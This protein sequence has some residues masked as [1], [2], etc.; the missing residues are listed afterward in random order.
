MAAQPRQHVHLLQK[1][2]ADAAMLGVLGHHLRNDRPM[3]PVL[4]TP[5]AAVVVALQL[6]PTLPRAIHPF[7]ERRQTRAAVVH[8]SHGQRPLNK[9]MLVRLGGR[10]DVGRGPDGTGA[11]SGGGSGRCAQWT[12]LLA[13]LRLHASDATKQL[14]PS[15]GGEP[16]RTSSRL[17]ASRGLPLPLGTWASP[18]A[19]RFIRWRRPE[20]SLLTWLAWLWPS[21]RR[22]LLFLGLNCNRAIHPRRSCS[23]SRRMLQGGAPPLE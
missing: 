14:L 10:P 15:Q 22:W 11:T 12:P 7:S 21:L 2:Q 20:R 18:P 8:A 3:L 5:D 6:L 17:L 9:P 4:V 1:T 19:A 13:S 23:W 16:P